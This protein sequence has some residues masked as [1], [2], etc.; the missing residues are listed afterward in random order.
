MKKFTIFYVLFI[1]LV[2]NACN[3]EQ[4]EKVV[5]YSKEYYKKIVE[6]HSGSANIDAISSKLMDRPH[7]FVDLNTTISIPDTI[8]K[9]N[10]QKIRYTL[11]DYSTLDEEK[12]IY[13]KGN[14][15]L[16]IVLSEQS[17]ENVKITFTDSNKKTFKCDKI[18]ITKNIAKC[19]SNELSV[20]FSIDLFSYGSVDIIYNHTDDYAIIQNGD[21]GIKDFNAMVDI[22]K[23]YPNIKEIRLKNIGG[24]LSQLTTQTGLLL[25]KH[26]L[27]TKVL[28][29][30]KGDDTDIASGGVDLFTAGVLRNIDK[31]SKLGVH[32]WS[33]NEEG[34]EIQAKDY[35]K[36][37]KAHH[38]QILYFTTMLGF[39]KGYDFYFFTINVA[40]G[41]NMHTMTLKEIEKYNFIK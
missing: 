21:L 9:V 24:S 7:S 2:F 10:N 39:E 8:I 37:D 19:N 13:K 38:D 36:N 27:N 18:K 40:F 5:P 22:T 35:A 17:D 29:V 41:D 15:V 34:K 11:K 32:S 30:N 25:R 23:N 14:N 4:E 28:T 16:K 6:N 33:S 31:G 26:G 12:I 3:K 1:L 20:E